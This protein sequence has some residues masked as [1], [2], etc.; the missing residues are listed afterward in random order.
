MYISAEP[1]IPP[2]RGDGQKHPIYEFYNLIH[3][4]LIPHKA[5]F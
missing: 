5:Y 1:L 2:F 4:P 3:F